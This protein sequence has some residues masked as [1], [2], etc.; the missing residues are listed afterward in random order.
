MG[1]RSKGAAS[2]PVELRAYRAE[3]QR[4]TRERDEA[5][6]VAAVAAAAFRAEARERNAITKKEEAMTV[7]EAIDKLS[8]LIAWSLRADSELSCI[9]QVRAIT[10]HDFRG[11]CLVQ[12]GEHGIVNWGRPLTKKEYDSLCPACR[13]YWHLQSARND[14]IEWVNQQ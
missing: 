3:I 14:L 9:R 5:R 1:R 2:P 11:S 13:A 6:E 12:V 8:D 10:L 4:L 7:R